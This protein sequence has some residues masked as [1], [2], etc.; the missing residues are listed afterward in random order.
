MK[1]IKPYNESI[2][3]PKKDGSYSK[4]EIED[5]FLEYIDEGR[6]SVTEGFL[7][8]DNRYF[9]DVAKVSNTSKKCIKVKITLEDVSTGVIGGSG[10]C[11][12]NMDILTNLLTKIRTF[13]SRTELQPNFIIVPKW[14]DIV[15]EFYVPGEVVEGSHLN[16]KEEINTLLTELLPIIKK[17]GYKR[18]SLKSANWFEVRTP[19]RATSD[20]GRRYGEAYVLSSMMRQ[21][22]EGGY[23]NSPY[24]SRVQLH[25]WCQKVQQAG[26]RIET[27]GGDN[28]VIFKLVKV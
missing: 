6:G 3:G 5:F 2:F 24:E 27:T 19:Q 14:D 22:R 13:Y 26:Y 25:N 8:K 11:L 28:Q 20:A 23:E 1:H 16:T 17:L 10:T 21:A 18:V 7:D 4:D 15:V 9:T 12:T